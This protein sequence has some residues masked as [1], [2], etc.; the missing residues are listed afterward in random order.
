M[1]PCNHNGRNTCMAEFFHCSGNLRTDRVL[2]HC[3]SQKGHS[4]LGKILS[5]LYRRPK[6]TPTG[7]R[8]FFCPPHVPC[9]FRYSHRMNSHL[10]S[11]GGAISKN[12]VRCTFRERNCP[13]SVLMH[14]RHTLSLRV[15]RTL[16]NSF[17]RIPDLFGLFFPIPCIFIRI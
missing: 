1:I 8:H 17:P 7:R 16:R 6:N 5:L 2:K 15:K 13:H 9:S 10:V 14:R 12:H 11:V 3:H 4:L